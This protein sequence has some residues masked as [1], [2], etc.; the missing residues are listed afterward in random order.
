LTLATVR[1]LKFRKFKNQ[2]WRRPPSWKIENW[3]YLRTNSPT[4]LSRYSGPNSPYCEHM[5]RRCCCLRIFFRLSIHALVA[6]TIVRCYPD[7]VFWHFCVLYFQPTACRVQHI[8]DMHSKFALKSHDLWKN[9]VDI[10]S[11]TAE[12]RRGKE[13]QR[14]KDEETTGRKHNVR[15]CYAQGGRNNQ[16]VSLVNLVP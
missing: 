9:M 15:I 14:K 10:Q 6:K 5:W 2:R 12:V 3:P 8:R 1:P 16:N 11:A 4:D 7:G 13:A